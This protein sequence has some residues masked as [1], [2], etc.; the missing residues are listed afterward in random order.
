MIKDSLCIGRIIGSNK[1]FKLVN[2]LNLRRGGLDGLYDRV[3][4]V[5]LRDR[6]TN[7]SY[8]IEDTIRF[9]FGRTDTSHP[10]RSFTRPEGEEGPEGRSFTTP[11]HQGPPDVS[12]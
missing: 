6:Q 4:F 2:N 3:S 12:R 1:E 5:S 10:A 9:P 7:S 8:F 11:S